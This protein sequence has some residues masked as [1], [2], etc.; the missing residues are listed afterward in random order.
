M[1]VNAASPVS[2]IFRSPT[3]FNLFFC[4]VKGSETNGRYNRNFPFVRE[5]SSSFCE[6]IGSAQPTFAR[7]SFSRQT[8]RTI[9]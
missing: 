9:R 4:I 2:L 1:R 6:R 7:L 3:D 8:W 5:D